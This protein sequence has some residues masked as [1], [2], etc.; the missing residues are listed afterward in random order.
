M[1]ANLSALKIGSLT[2]TPEFSPGV[3]SYTSSTSNAT[4]SVSATPEDD[5]ASV[6]IKLNGEDATSPVTWEIGENV[7]SVEVA[8]GDAKKTYTV[9]VTKS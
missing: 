8:N 3:T 9:T 1:S 7:L 2:L 6:K 4:N 5:G